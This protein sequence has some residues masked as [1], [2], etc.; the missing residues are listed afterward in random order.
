M[1]KREAQ[2]LAAKIESDDPR[3]RVSGYRLYAAS[4][5]RGSIYAIDCTDTRTGDR[6]VIDAPEDW[7]ERNF[8]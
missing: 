5:G 3:V 4:I 6:F 8:R 2:R 7:A 1:H